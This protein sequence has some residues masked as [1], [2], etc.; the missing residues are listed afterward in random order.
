MGQGAGCQL[1]W[2][3]KGAT[4][5]NAASPGRRGGRLR[6]RSDPKKRGRLCP[7]WDRRK[8]WPPSVQLTELRKD[9][10]NWSFA[11]V[12][13]ILRDYTIFRVSTGGPNHS[14][15]IQCPGRPGRNRRFRRRR[16]SYQARWR[17]LAFWIRRSVEAETRS[18]D[19]AGI[20]KV[21]SRAPL[22]CI[23]FSN[24]LL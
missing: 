9:E 8:R 13:M 12:G 4:D 18:V 3:S 6:L 2:N 23:T 15:G 7:F 14:T 16:P 20:P 21:Q 24:G 19:T 11:D 22:V 17:R 10:C 5:K 1:I